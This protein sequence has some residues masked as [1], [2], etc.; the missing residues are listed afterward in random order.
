[1]IKKNL[2]LSVAVPSLFVVNVSAAPLIGQGPRLNPNDRITHDQIVNG[3][4]SLNE[5]R[6]A[7]LLIF[8]T[9]FNKLDGFGDGDYNPS[10]P[11]NAP[12][13]G[14]RPTLQNN[15]T[16]LRINGLDAQTCL[17]CHTIVSNATVPAT[18]GVG[19]VGGINSSPLFRP[20]YIEPA[21]ESADGFAF[22]D[23]RL[24][25]PP[26]LFGSGG[27]ELVGREMTADLQAIKAEAI[28]V[29]GVPKLLVSKGVNFGSIAADADGD[30]DTTNV[31]GVDDDLVV[32]PFGRKGEFPS[33][34]DFDIGA[35]AFHFGMQATELVG[36]NNDQD[37]DG[38]VNEMRVGDL[39]ALSI[40]NTT[41]DRPRT[42]AQ[43]RETTSGFA[44]FQQIGCG[45]CHI[46][47]M[48][49]NSK[50]LQYKLG[51]DDSP[52]DRPFQDTYYQVDLTQKPAEF[53]ASGNGIEV[54]M[55]SDLK[56]HN[57]GDGLKESMAI[58]D[59]QRNREFITPRLWGIADTAPYL[60]DGRALT[61]E[62]AIAAHNS[63]GSEASTVAKAFA[64]LPDVEKNRILKFLMTLHTPK[65]PN[66][67]V[68]ESNWSRSV[69]AP[70]EN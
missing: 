12:D 59:D 65:K 19:G 35:M 57:M 3:Q 8:T 47:A 58:A 5:I 50:Y 17:E 28:A 20:T 48:T 25:N 9:P 33:V 43:N 55:F 67:D 7:G 45:G 46:P 15:G 40:F 13:S 68:L 44:K 53:D 24:I 31:R 69:L 64:N 51:A 29:P 39:S 1:M 70:I 30:I 63:P 16:F 38:V 61:L 6:K 14:N 49:T 18:L 41:S 4:L 60:H 22:F 54:P 34:R 32:K 37:N 52:A 56:K 2:I 23:G 21:D 66:A 11:H 62:D 27:V 36:E 10:E 42:G 26:F